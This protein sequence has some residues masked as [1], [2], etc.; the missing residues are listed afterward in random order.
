MLWATAMNDIRIFE[1]DSKYETEA[2]EKSSDEKKT[3]IK[4]LLRPFL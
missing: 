2:Q 1:M 3:E 4:N